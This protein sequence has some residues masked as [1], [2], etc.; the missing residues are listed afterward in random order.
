MPR[1][2]PTPLPAPSTATG[3]PISVAEVL[4]GAERRVRW[5]IPP[6]LRVRRGYTW[7]RLDRH[8]PT[9]WPQGI[10]SS[11]D[12]GRS[13]LAQRLLLV[14]WYSKDGDG[15]RITFLDLAT[16]RYTHVPLALIRDGE[17]APLAAHAGG[18]AWRGPWLYVAATGRGCY[19]AHLDD[20]RR[21]PD[22]SL[23]WPVRLR[24]VA[25]DGMRYS[26]LSVTDAG[27]LMAGEYGGPAQPTR[28]AR[29]PLDDSGALLL[30]EDGTARA[31][32]VDVGVPSMQGATRIGERYE[33]MVSRGRRRPGDLWEGRAG[34]LRVR[35]FAAPPGPEDV[36][37]APATGL[38]W[39]VTE[40]PG[41]RWIFALRPGRIH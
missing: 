27:E 22:G 25:D 35:S 17:L 36:S 19:A 40:F 28:L 29:F 16:R 26:F 31:H 11:V 9:W 8:D 34:E 2:T 3:E 38:L 23:T 24:Y 20:L 14:S 6:G 10:T 32:T 4:A 13:D 15:V 18:L 37:Y 5:A 41:R 33:L 30:G 39:G 12:A 1:L 7:D 21:R